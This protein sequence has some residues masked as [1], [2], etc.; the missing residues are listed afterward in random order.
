MDKRDLFRERPIAVSAAFRKTQP[1]NR[2]H[3]RYPTRTQNPGLRR[4]KKSRHRYSRLYRQRFAQAFDAFDFMHR[5]RG[6]I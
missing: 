5:L 3:S 4:R 6:E 1:S 2:Q